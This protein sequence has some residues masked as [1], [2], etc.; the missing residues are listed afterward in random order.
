[1]VLHPRSWKVSLGMYVGFRNVWKH[2]KVS[3]ATYYPRYKAS[4]TIWIVWSTTQ[5]PS[6]WAGEEMHYWRSPL[7]I[8]FTVY[9]LAI[10]L[11]SNPVQLKFCSIG[12][13]GSKALCTEIAPNDSACS[14]HYDIMVYSWFFSLFCPRQSEYSLSLYF[15]L[16]I[17]SVQRLI[18]L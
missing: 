11:R 6:R 2:L 15:V 13:V 18:N 10:E 4:P 1:M 7:L 8:H 16:E 12:Q 9:I 5:T 17:S 14:S 3:M